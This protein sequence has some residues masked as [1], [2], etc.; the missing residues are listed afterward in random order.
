[1]DNPTVRNMALNAARQNLVGARQTSFQKMQMPDKEKVATAKTPPLQLTPITTTGITTKVENSS[2]DKTI[3][4]NR[5]LNG[6]DP[7]VLAENPATDNEI[8]E[9]TIVEGVKSEPEAQKIINSGKDIIRSTVSQHFGNV[10]DSVIDSLFDTIERQ[11]AS[12]TILP[13]ALGKADASWFAKQL[14]AVVPKKEGESNLQYARKMQ[15]AGETLKKDINKWY[16]DPTSGY[17]K[18]VEKKVTRALKDG[19]SRTAETS[20]ISIGDETEGNKALEW[21]TDNMGYAVPQQD[22]YKVKGEESSGLWGKGLKT[23]L[24][25]IPKEDR[26]F[27]I[28][29]TGDGL[30][31]FKVANRFAPN[32]TID[33]KFDPKRLEGFRG[34]DQYAKFAEFFGDASIFQEALLDEVNLNVNDYDG[35]TGLVRTGMWIPRTPEGGLSFPVNS[36]VTPDDVKKHVSWKPRVIGGD[37]FYEVT[38]SPEK[39]KEYAQRAGLP[40]N[41]NFPIK[42]T[43]K[44]EMVA[45]VTELFK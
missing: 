39:M 21:I 5:L 36:K 6:T 15:K 22:K 43:T 19:S 16:S 26:V 25:G 24:D 17:F 12:T 33:F 29:R 20:V 38:L 14:E 44:D 10:D 32:E 1:M 34:Y 40:S 30:P 3:S 35:I 31:T 23:A 8:L 2:Y 28:S 45:L 11:Y 27:S 7:T 18:N 9:A 37:T 42:V 41:S 13:R 4:N